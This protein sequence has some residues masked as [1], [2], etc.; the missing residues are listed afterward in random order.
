MAMQVLSSGIALATALVLAFE[1]LIWLRLAIPLSLF[2]FGYVFG[3][4]SRCVGHCCC[5]LFLRVEMIGMRCDVRTFEVRAPDGR[6]RYPT[7]PVLAQRQTESNLE[8]AY[9]RDY[10]AR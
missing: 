10:Q 5:H 6:E 8:D 3:V 4:V 1:F 7:P 9:I 2:W